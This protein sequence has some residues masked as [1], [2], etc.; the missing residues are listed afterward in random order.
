MASK[1]NEIKRLVGKRIREER[2]TAGYTLEKFAAESGLDPSHLSRIERGE[3]G[4]D[5]LVLARIAGI[6]NLPMDAFFDEERGAAVALARGSK[7]QRDPMV[8]WGLELLADM[9][10]AEQV[11]DARSW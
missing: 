11:V 2:L 9:A 6:V 3:R 4:L 1:E 8:D 7:A 10:Y 5:S